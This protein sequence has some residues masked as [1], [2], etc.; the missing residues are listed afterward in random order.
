MAD[1]EYRPLIQYVFIGGIIVYSVC[2]FWK[3]PLRV[4]NNEKLM[5]VLNLTGLNLHKCPINEENHAS[6]GQNNMQGYSDTRQ[7]ENNPKTLV[8]H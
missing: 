4:N 7:N 8:G 3:T 5:S 2:Y 6:I 1:V